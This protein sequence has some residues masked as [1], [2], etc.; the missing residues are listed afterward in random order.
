MFQRLLLPRGYYANFAGVLVGTQGESRFLFSD[1]RK[2]G[3]APEVRSPCGYRFL[4]LA[5]QAPLY[6]FYRVQVA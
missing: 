5:L 2:W 4:P 3:G 6:S 1:A